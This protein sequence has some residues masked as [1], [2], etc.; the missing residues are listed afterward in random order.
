[1]L[2]NC[3]PTAPGDVDEIAFI[4]ARGASAIDRCALKILAQLDVVGEAAGAE[5]DGLAREETLLAFGLIGLDADDIAGGISDQSLH[6]VAGANV[7]AVALGRRRQVRI[8]TS[9][10]SDMLSR[11][12]LG[13]STRPFGA[14]SSGSSA[15]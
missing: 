10:P 5:H 3:A 2:R 1:M 14:L 11:A 15:Q 13:S 7:D 8:A 9:P 4:A 6:P 12:P